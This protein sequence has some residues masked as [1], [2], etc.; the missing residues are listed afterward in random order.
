MV[1]KFFSEESRDDH[2]SE[3]E[4]PDL[5]LDTAASQ[6]AAAYQL[7]GKVNLPQQQPSLSA[8]YSAISI[9]QST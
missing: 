1:A 4:E 6:H 5:F 9:N 2:L 3:A 8:E 7:V